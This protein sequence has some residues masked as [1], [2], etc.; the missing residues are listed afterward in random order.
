MYEVIEKRLRGKNNSFERNEEAFY[1]LG[2]Q[3]LLLR[4]KAGRMLSLIKQCV[5]SRLFQVVPDCFNLFQTV[6]KCSRMFQ[7]APDCSRSCG[8]VQKTTLKSICLTTASG[9]VTLLQTINRFLE[10]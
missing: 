3:L 10:S 1:K 6:S 7:I 8:L 4:A 2:Y 5:C 9:A